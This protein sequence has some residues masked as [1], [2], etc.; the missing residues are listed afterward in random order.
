MGED[1]NTNIEAPVLII[2]GGQAGF[3]VALSLRDGGY[4]SAIHILCEE[5][6]LPYQ[7]PP[8]SKAYLMGKMKADNLSFRPEAFFETQNIKLH[9][10]VI[11]EHIDPA[12]KVVRTAGGE[13]F[14][15]EHLVI[16]TGTRVRKLPVE[17]AQLGGV[18]Y[19]RSMADSDAIAGEFDQAQ[20]VVVIGGGFIGLEVAAVSAGLG[21]KATV[22]EAADRLMARAVT[23]PVS[24][25]FSKL[26][27]EGGVEVL[28]NSAVQSLAGENGKVTQV[29]CADGRAIDADLVVI[30][31]GVVPNSEIAEAAGIACPNG[32]EVDAHG[33]SSVPDIYSAGDCACHLSPF[34]NEMERLE[35]VQNAI[36]QARTVAATI[37]GQDVPY[38]SVPWFW[39]DQF[40]VKL[41]MVGFS[42]GYDA[43]AIRGDQAS[44]K[45]SLFY[46][47]GD[48]LIG[49]DSMSRPADHM[50]GRKILTANA[51]LTKEQAGDEEFDLRGFI[52]AL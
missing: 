37:L 51:N 43:Y 47:K 32:I 42:K 18:H 49:V 30:G 52:K 2:G 33:R 6:V 29:I 46:F 28:L 14:K 21:K 13:H 19:L 38:H 41:Q 17:G 31:I 12:K 36:D 39:S 25:Y 48:K 35:S 44:G 26:H 16:A 45:F 3:Q 40:D 5:A 22:I 1:V 11:A 27:S 24:E 34:S 7:R 20:N 9:K 4:E 10:G 8:L 15:Y 23:P 50:A